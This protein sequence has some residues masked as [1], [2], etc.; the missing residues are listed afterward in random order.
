VFDLPF[1]DRAF[2]GYLS[3]GVIEHY[4]DGF[5]RAAEEMARCLR[6]GGLLFLAFPHMSRLRRLK[7]S[8]GR[9]AEWAGSET[10]PAD[11]YQFALDDRRVRLRY[12]R[13]GFQCVEAVRLLGATGLEHEV[14]RMRAIMKDTNRLSRRVRSV[15]DLTCRWFCSHCILLV[16]RKQSEA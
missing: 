10:S 14:P 2:D 6:S 5:D 16:L 1:R 15:V 7:A 12:H 11:F 4:F 13:L 3:L 8:S 9:Y